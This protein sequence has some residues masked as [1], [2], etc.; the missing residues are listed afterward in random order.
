MAPLCPPRPEGRSAWSMVT[1]GNDRSTSLIGE[2]N[3]GDVLTQFLLEY[4][5]GNTPEGTLEAVYRLVDVSR[6]VSTVTDAAAWTPYQER[7]SLLEAAGVVLGGGPDAL[8]RVGQCVFDSIRNPQRMEMLRS[9]GSPAAVYEALPSFVGLYAPAF[10][11]ATELLGPNE[12]RVEMRM[13][14][15]NEPFPELCA[16]GFSMAST[17]P[18]L[19]GCSVAEVTHESCL[20]DGAPC[21]SALLRWDPPD[22]EKAEKNG[23]EMQ[24]RL[25]EAR[26]DELQR[27][28]AELGSGDGLQHVLA[29]VMAGAMRAVQAPVFI[30]DIKASAT[31]RRFIRTK[32]IG[33]FE[34]AEVTRGLHEEEE[35]V[36]V[37]NVLVTDVASEQGHYGYLVAMRPEVN[38]FD[39]QERSVL[40]SYSRLAASALDA[41]AAVVEARRQAMMAQALL[42]LSGS[43]G[44]LATSEEMAQHLARTIPSV[45][46]CDRAIVS[47]A[48]SAGETTWAFATYGFDAGIEAELRGIEPQSFIGSLD[49]WMYRH[50][51]DAPAGGL[52]AT[53]VSS[54]SLAA[55]SHGISLNGEL[56]G[57]ITI[58]VTA[59]PERLDDDLETAERLRGLA[60]QTAIAIYNTRLLEEIR[61][62][63]LHDSLTG[64]PN[65]VLILD[66]VE[67]AMARARRD[68]VD[69][70]LL[71]IDLDGFKD[72]NDDLG[73]R[74]GDDLLRSVAARFSGTLRESDTVARL[75]G[76][77]FVVLVEGISLAAG[78]ELVAERLLGV[79]A[80]PFDLG[81]LND[82]RI[83]VSVSASIG[84]AAGVRESTEELFRDADVALY[85]AK[86]A[87][88][89]GYVIFESEMYNTMHSRHELELDLQA[90]VGTD[91]FFLCYQ[92]IF[93]LSDMAVIGV[94]ALLRWNHPTK[95][96]LQP[97]EFISALEASG[98]ITPVGRWVMR[99]ACRQ[100]M[101][102]RQAGHDIKMSVNASARQL[103][104]DTLLNDVCQALD[105]SG[106]PAESL[107]VEITETCLMRDAK[108]ALL[109]LNALKS[110]GVR[111]A[112]DDFGTG[113]SSLAY[114]QQ[115]PVDSLK[116]D[117]SF[118]SGMGKSAEGDTLI[119]T[120]IQLG[121]ALKLE[122]LAEG[123]EEIDQLTQLRGEQCDVGQGYLFSRPMVP[124]DIEKLLGQTSARTWA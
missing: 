109:Q 85:R 15:P 61:Y 37:A 105:E 25:L 110:L 16:L 5:E 83:A 27:T 54:G 55:R 18:Q 62:Q 108:G 112:I 88:K 93:T 9:L 60:G 17:L 117:R 21:C 43:L 99:Q 82:R 114:L 86:E 113:Y 35:T 45:I 6:K 106:L 39:S 49:S 1:A 92:P 53:L 10:T 50:P 34:G 101:A 77:E 33:E 13:V 14:A 7:R 115:F 29:R 46:D 63:A 124:E 48:L 71:F 74:I 26:L 104:A 57:W 118:I 8:T 122:T 42:T 91:Q 22:G 58:D 23:A 100:A 96:L 123:I 121:K 97:D 90:A 111:I 24:I 47:L 56:F 44:S 59:R 11:M 65:R 87:G 20:C 41:E 64:L 40:E 72:V 30:L 69:M 2:R 119:H 51:V 84:I 120:L 4:L 38:G 32:G 36:P 98:L 73:H 103:D 79:L 95:G 94:E 76:D 3:G 68:H 89:N 75:G 80:E 102:W 28:V 116:I 70:A 52:S 81:G 78:P 66:R 12:C 67:R 31:S 19:F 107:I